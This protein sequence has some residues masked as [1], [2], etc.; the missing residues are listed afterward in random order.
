MA[1]GSG[2]LLAELISRDVPSLDPA[3]Y[4]L[5]RFA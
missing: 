1:A 2:Q 3:P 5:K 4:D